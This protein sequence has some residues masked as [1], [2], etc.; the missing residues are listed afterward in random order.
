VDIAD[1]RKVYSIFI[2]EN[3]ST[4]YLNEC[5]SDF[6]FNELLPPA[7]VTGAGGDTQ[8]MDIATQVI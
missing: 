6:M 7:P 5:Q 4:Q 3:R 2:D 1:V 8:P